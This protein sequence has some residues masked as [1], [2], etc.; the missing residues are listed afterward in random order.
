MEGSEKKSEVAQDVIRT[1]S[2]S[3]GLAK[4]RGRCDAG[5]WFHIS[6][7]SQ[8]RE[9]LAPQNYEC[10]KTWRCEGEDLHEIGGARA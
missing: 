6:T 3:R 2:Q 5:D 1:H 9:C 10:S 7:K 4:S 8:K